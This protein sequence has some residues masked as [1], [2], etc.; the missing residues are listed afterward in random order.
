M[1]EHLGFVQAAF[2][3]E[4]EKIGG[5]GSAIKN[6]LARGGE[7][8]STLAKGEK[9]LFGEGGMIAASKER[10][11]ALGTLPPEE[12]LGIWGKTKHMVQNDPASAMAALG[13]G[14]LL[15]AGGLYEAGKDRG[16]HGY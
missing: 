5:L 7:G 3:D 16:R 9:K 6:I 15:A 11:K 4:L 12:Q 8:V 14:G 1:I 13:G 2:L 10:L